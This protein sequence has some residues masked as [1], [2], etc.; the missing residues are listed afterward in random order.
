MNVLRRNLANSV[1]FYSKFA[2]FINFLKIRLVLS[3]K[4]SIFLGK[5]PNFWTFW[6]FLH[7][8]WP[9]I[10]I[11]LFLAILKK[12]KNFFEKPIYVFSNK[13]LKFRTFWDIFL[14]QLQSASNWS[15]LAVSKKS[16]DNFWTTNFFSRRNHF[17][18]VLRS[19]TNSVASYNKFLS[20]AISTKSIFFEKP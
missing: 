12:S 2:T 8:Q 17:L 7:F 4:P 1:A 3:K 19:L 13:K 15:L 6:E 5:T 9:C 10:A 16:Q 11:F 18:K 20:L 14:I